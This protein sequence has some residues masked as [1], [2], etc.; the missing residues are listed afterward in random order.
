MSK[1][2]IATTYGINSDK[3]YYGESFKKGN[4]KMT[5]FQSKAKT[6]NTIEEAMKIYKKFM[7]EN[8]NIADHFVRAF[9]FV[10]EI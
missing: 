8:S 7:G 3:L 1:F 10:K 2:V 4:M 6:F 5:S 9:P